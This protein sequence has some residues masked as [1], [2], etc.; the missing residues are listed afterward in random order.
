MRQHKTIYYCLLP[1]V[2][3]Y[4]L[5]EERKALYAKLSQSIG[6]TAVEKYSGPVPNNNRIWIKR[7]CD[8]L[9]GSHYDRVYLATYRYWEENLGL[10][11]DIPVLESTSGTAGVSFAGIGRKLGYECYVMVPEGK[12]L[13]KRREAIAAEGGKIILT[14]EAEYIQ[15]F[16]PRLLPTIKELGAKFFNHSM[17]VKKSNNEITLRSLEDIA[18]EAL[19]QVPVDCFVA[20]NGNGS[21]ILGPGRVFKK[22]NPE[23]RI[24]AYKPKVSGA[25]E[26]PGLMNQEETN[27]EIA[28]NFPHLA[29]AQELIE[30][31]ITIE[32]WNKNVVGHK[33][34]G[35]TGRAGISVALN[36]AK[37]F[38]DKDILVIGYDKAE[39][40]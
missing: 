18:L 6:N 33:D 1:V 16:A 28:I 27:P 11:P 21:S 24:F 30:K 35:K 10:N 32:D 12:Q 40:Y 22:Y 39:R 31:T 20:G 7:E 15:G 8:N 5:S 9:F 34:I 29:Q 2:M 17:G 3:K 13:Q 37:E 23:I 19:Q 36:L 25:S 26:L 4:E 14:P 38:K